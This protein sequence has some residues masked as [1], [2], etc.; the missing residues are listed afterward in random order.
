M[1]RRKRTRSDTVR[2]LP[3]MF[4][5]SVLLM[6]SLFNVA[7]NHIGILRRVYFIFFSIILFFGRF[8]CGNLGER[9]KAAEQIPELERR[10]VRHGCLKND[11]FFSLEKKKKHKT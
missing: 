3:F 10:T 8:E 7:V 1:S 6:Y 5:D 9:S 11:L 2:S 4:Y